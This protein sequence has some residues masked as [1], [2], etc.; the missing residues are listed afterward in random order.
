MGMLWY[1]RRM[2]TYTYKLDRCKNVCPTFLTWTSVN[3]FV[4]D[5]YIN[6]TTARSGMVTIYH[7]VTQHQPI[8][9]QLLPKHNYV[10]I[11]KCIKLSHL[12]FWLLDMGFNN[13]V[14]YK[15]TYGETCLFYSFG[16][17]YISQT[18]RRERRKHHPPP[19]SWSLWRQCT[20]CFLSYQSK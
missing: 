13:Y 17:S 2:Y 18:Y 6:K 19:G 5:S 12:G 11:T 20:C 8:Q 7:R 3:M 10:G 14:F 9:I 1:D 4:S 15:T 16:S